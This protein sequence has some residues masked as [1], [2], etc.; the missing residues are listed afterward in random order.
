MSEEEIA[1]SENG[2]IDVAQLNALY[3]LIG[4]DRSNRR[5]DEETVEML[6]ASRYYMA[7][8][9]PPVGLV[10]FARVCGDPYVVQVLDVITHPDFRHRGVV[11]HCMQGVVRHLECSR[12]VTVTMT[13]SPGLEK[14]YERFG[15]EPNGDQS[16][17]A[18]RAALPAAAN[19]RA[20]Q[21]VSRDDLPHRDVGN[22]PANHGVKSPNFHASPALFRSAHPAAPRR[23]GL[24]KALLFDSL[25][26][27]VHRA[28]N[29]DRQI[30]TWVGMTEQL[31]R[32]L[33]FLLQ[34]RGSV[35]LNPIAR[36]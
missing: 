22:V 1:F 10:G 12:Y 3:R 30:T 36:C 8:H 11:T 9:S 20:P 25:D 24:G 21:T 33:E 31:E 16:R 2:P 4:W 5:S 23:L 28:L 15:F 18:R 14:F 17:I 35:Q 7:A 27:Q 26:E 32:V 34:L 6:K 29:H 19:E 13:H